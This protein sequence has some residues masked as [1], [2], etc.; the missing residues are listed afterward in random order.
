LSQ[1]LNCFLANDQV[2]VPGTNP[3][4]TRFIAQGKRLFRAPVRSCIWASREL[5]ITQLNVD[6]AD[7][8]AV[9]AHIEERRLIIVSIYIPDLCARRT[10]E[11]NLEELSSRLGAISKLIQEEKLRNPHTESIIASDFNRHNLL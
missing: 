4:W 10:K 6:S 8:T 9:M 11:E 2:V 1:E 3:R 7:I 5:A